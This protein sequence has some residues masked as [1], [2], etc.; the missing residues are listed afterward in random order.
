M[1][2]QKSNNMILQENITINGKA[3]LRTY[4]DSNL[5]IIQLETGINYVDAI[6]LLP[7][8]YHY[9]ETEIELPKE[10]TVMEEQQ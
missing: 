5:Y 1:K 10:N 8:N 7:C 2:I 4:S 9:V 6:D 3:F